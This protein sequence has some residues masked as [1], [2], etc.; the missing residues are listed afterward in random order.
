MSNSLNQ[1]LLLAPKTSTGLKIIAALAAIV[2]AALL[3]G[4]YFMLRQRHAENVAASIPVAEPRPEPRAIILVDDA[5]IGGGK[6]TLAGTIKNTSN[7]TLSNLQVELELKSRK[8]AGAEKRL[9]PVEPA[10]L[11]PNQEGRYSIQLAVQDYASARLIGLKSGGDLAAVPYTTG[12]GQKRQPERL[13]SKTITVD[14]R[15]PGGKRDEFL[16]SPDNPARVP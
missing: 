7:G 2:V 3:L 6:S 16:N 14:K 1:E 12:Q 15:P 9:V 13:E 5:T 11:Q 8:G 10:D 4:G